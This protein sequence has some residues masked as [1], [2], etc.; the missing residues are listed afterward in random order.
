MRFK[1]RLKTQSNV[2]LIPMIDVVFQL[3]IFFMV[4]TTFVI[5]PGI[6]LVLPS[7]STSEPV[8]MSRL[9]V[10]IV[11]RDEVYFNK[12]RFSLRGLGDR[13]AALSEEER[14]EIKTVVLEGDRG[15]SYAL[16]IE[17]LDVLRRSI[18]Y[19]NPGGAVGRMGDREVAGQVTLD[20]DPMRRRDPTLGGIGATSVRVST[21]L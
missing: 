14:Q 20:L 17:V 7:S 11:A 15:I 6:S 16:M 10:T 8:L 18:G 5:T 21:P 9:V 12:E 4:S 19:R 2:N 13:L 1:R 3:V